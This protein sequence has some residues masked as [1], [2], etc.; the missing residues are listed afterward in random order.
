MDA[1]CHESKVTGEPLPNTSRVDAAVA[2][3]G[4]EPATFKVM[5][6]MVNMFD[7]FSSSN[8]TC[9]F[10]NI[11]NAIFFNWLLDGVSGYF[12]M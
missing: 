1:L 10:S 11:Y 4:F 12:I 6:E 7:Y 5:S 8:K 3:A 9:I 2:G